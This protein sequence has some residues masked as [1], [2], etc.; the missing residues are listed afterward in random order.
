M[1]RMRMLTLLLFAL[2]LWSAPMTAQQVSGDTSANTESTIKQLQQAVSS[3]DQVILN[4]EQRVEALEQAA[5]HASSSS[6]PVTS[7]SSPVRSNLVTPRSPSPALDDDERSARATLDRTLISRGGLLLRPWTVEVENSFNYYNASSD[8][9]SVNGYTILPVLVVGDIISQR[10]R[11][12]I[13]LYNLNTRLGLPRDFQF[14]VRVPYGLEIERSFS[15]DGTQTSKRATGIGDVEIAL[16]KQVYHQ[17][18]GW[19]DLLTGLRWK[20]TTGND[21]Y[22]VGSSV[23]TLGNGFPALQASVTAVKSSDP[24]V[25]FGSISYTANLPRYKPVANTNPDNP[26]STVTGHVD[27][28]DTIGSSIG[29]AL[30]INPAASISVAYEQSFTRSTSLNGLHIPGSYLNEGILRLGTSYMYALGRTIDISL[31]IGL[32]RDTPDFQF[33]ASL[34]FRFSLRHNKTALPPYQASSDRRE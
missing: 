24:A 26:L 5:Q 18:N 6:A 22:T 14:E 17:K 32:T 15:A 12:D 33:S 29:A 27:P 20:T 21:P 28:G 23:P 4:L 16:Y 25:F 2:T 10:T 3:R 34:P 11:S 1:P 31:G 13:V 9:V 8:N 7:A 19:P 30:A